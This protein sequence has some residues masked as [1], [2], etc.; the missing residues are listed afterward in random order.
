MAV[1]TAST[2]AAL[3]LPLVLFLAGT[4]LLASTLGRDDRTVMHRHYALSLC[5]RPL[6][7][8]S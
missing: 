8:P 1:A 7:N 5:V 2:G 3:F 6:R 4:L